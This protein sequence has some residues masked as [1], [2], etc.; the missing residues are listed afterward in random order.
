[1][2]NTKFYSL[3]SL[4]VVLLLS[5]STLV[6]C[7]TA[8]IDKIGLKR[9][10]NLS[11][12]ERLLWRQAL[13]FPSHCTDGIY[14]WDDATHPKLRFFDVNAEKYLVR[15]Y[16]GIMPDEY[17]LFLVNKSNPHEKPHLLEL[18]IPVE[19]GNTNTVADWLEED[20]TDE[21]WARRAEHDQLTA[22]YT[23]RISSLLQ[24]AFSVNEQGQLLVIRRS[25]SFTDKCGT[26]SLY[27]LSNNQAKLVSF[28]AQSDCMGSNDVSRWKIYDE[29][30]LIPTDK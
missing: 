14:E 30:D 15:S 17:N 21:D 13:G 24:G 3:P 12:E 2:T 4:I 8:P 25:V 11:I 19:A 7:A 18:K 29:S 20:A 28:R 23:S 1:M 5:C 10:E 22:I 9:S 27:D 6:G 16:C 26:H